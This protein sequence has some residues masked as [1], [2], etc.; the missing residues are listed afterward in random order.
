MKLYSNPMAPSAQRVTLFLAE[1]SLDIPIVEV[2]VRAGEQLGD[3]YRKINPHCMVPCLEL[4]SGDRLTE[5][6]AICRYLEAVHPE[7]SLFGKTPEELGRIEMWNRYC[8]QDGFM[9]VGHY[10]RNS[11]DGFKDRGLPGPHNYEQIP[12]LAE[13]AKLRYGHFSDALDRRLGESE[14]VA[15]DTFSCADITAF[16]GIRA[17]NAFHLS[18]GDATTNIMRWYETVSSRPS[19]L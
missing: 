2:D 11:F 4:D 15:G 12:E 3:E 6:M 10:L 14:F 13:R 17:G 18:L 7:P 16:V 19:V 9:S 8:E 1:K 5:S